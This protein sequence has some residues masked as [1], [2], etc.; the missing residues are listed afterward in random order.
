[1]RIRVLLAM[2]L[3]VLVSATAAS[4]HGYRQSVGPFV[5]DTQLAGISSGAAA[6][7]GP[8]TP[9]GSHIACTAGRR[10][11]FSIPLRNRSNSP[12]TLTGASVDPPSAQIVQRVAVQFRLAPPDPK[13]DVLVSWLGRWS[14]SQ[15]TAV[16]VAPGHNVWVQEDFLMRNCSLLASDQALV[17]NRSITLAY[18]TRARTSSQQL[19][20]PGARLIVTP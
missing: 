14:R 11:A 12:V 2:P 1:M 17:A 9:T 3:L 15:A 7:D 16:T 6:G 10:Y 8:S 4:A 5:L 20:I 18:R 19:G 13:G